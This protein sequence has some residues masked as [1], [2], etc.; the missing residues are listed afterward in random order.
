LL[1]IDS[2][3]SS[4]L[5]IASCFSFTAPSG[6]YTWSESGTY[7]DTITNSIGCDSVI[8]FNLTIDSVP[9]DTEAIAKSL[10]DS[11]SVNE[12]LQLN[13]DGYIEKEGKATPVFSDS[14][15][16]ASKEGMISLYQIRDYKNCTDTAFIKDINIFQPKGEEVESTPCFVKVSPNPG[17]EKF[18]ISANQEL[19]DLGIYD[20]SGRL[21]RGLDAPTT[22]PVTV[23][24]TNWP[25]GV[26]IIQARCKDN[27]ILRVK[28]LRK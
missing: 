14:K 20:A 19:Q 18:T 23:Q 9:F 5:A 1:T 21:V 15:W 6:N 27:E 22:P 2:S 3:T 16:Q 12:S 17:E 25:A 11:L 28:W 26:Y 13:I 8:T 10:P 4:T 24:T 7:L